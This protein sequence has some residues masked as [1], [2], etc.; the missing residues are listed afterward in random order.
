MI[1]ITN[2]IFDNLGVLA[3][4]SI[5]VKFASINDNSWIYGSVQAKNSHDNYFLMY[6]P[7]DGNVDEPAISFGSTCIKLVRRV[8]EPDSVMRHDF[9]V[10]RLAR[11]VDTFQRDVG[12][13][14]SPNQCL[15]GYMEGIAQLCKDHDLKLTDDEHKKFVQPMEDVL[16]RPTRRRRPDEQVFFLHRSN[17]CHFFF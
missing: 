9:L 4:L 16:N 6:E 13:H 5:V 12:H 1:H 10:T 17:R 15:L 8:G 11:Y 2:D 14:S 3:G 7:S